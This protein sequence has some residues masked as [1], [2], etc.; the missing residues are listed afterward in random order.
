MRADLAAKEPDPASERPPAGAD[1]A[2]LSLSPPPEAAE[3]K[4]ELSKK[5][6]AL[7]QLAR[8][9]SGESSSREEAL[10]AVLVRLARALSQ[11]SKVASLGDL[12]PPDRAADSVLASFEEAAGS[13]AQLVTSARMRL[14]EPEVDGET[15]T[16]AV[17]LSGGCPRSSGRSRARR[18]GIA[19]SR[20]RLRS[21]TN[22]FGM[23]SP[24]RWLLRSRWR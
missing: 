15:A 22:F 14:S 23:S 24:P 11:I 13:L 19:R 21:S 3:T 7:T 6:D 20:S 12:A 9:L 16:L 8:D 10:R 4:D 17:A 2:T 18:R 1:E 5:L